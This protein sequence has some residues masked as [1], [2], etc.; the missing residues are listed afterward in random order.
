VLLAGAVALIA[1][2]AT[3][4]RY[5]LPH[6]SLSAAV[7]S[8]VII[9]LVIKHLGLLGSLF[10]LF[11]H[12]LGPEI[13]R[14]EFDWRKPSKNRVTPSPLGNGFRNADIATRL[15]EPSLIFMM[16]QESK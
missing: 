9:L 6:A 11:R 10:A 12:A 1:L 4:L 15:R 13:L 16:G 7:V 14:W 3:I 8:G 5:V 2:H